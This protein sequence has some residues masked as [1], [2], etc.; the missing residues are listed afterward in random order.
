MSDPTADM[1]KTEKERL[2]VQKKQNEEMEK[3][4]EIVSALNDV[5]KKQKKLLKEIAQLEKK[6]RTE[7]EEKRLKALK[8]ITA[9]NQKEIDQLEKKNKATEELLGTT[10][11]I[12]TT[13]EKQRALGYDTTKT[14]D[15][16]RDL[17]IKY[18]EVE[19]HTAKLGKKKVAKMQEQIEAEITR[20]KINDESARL[21]Q[22]EEKMRKKMVGQAEEL[23]ESA[24]QNVAMAK[25]FIR[26]LAT[27]PYLAILAAIMAVVKALEFLNAKTKEF[28]KATNTSVVQA[29]E[30]RN[31]LAGAQLDAAML[32]YS[33]S[34]AAGALSK[35][36]GS[37]S[38]I[39]G[40]TVKTMGR[41]EKGLNISMSTSAKLMKS[42]EGVGASSDEAQVNS[43]KFAAE[44]AI[45]NDV[46]PGDV[47]ESIAGDTESF[48]KYG[49][50]GGKNM[51]RAAV[52]AK[53]LGLEMSTLAKMSDSLLNFESSI[54]A[55]MEA[56]MLIGKQLNYNKA[57]ELALSGDLE[58]ATK[59]IMSQIGGAAEFQKMNVMQR[60]ALADSV[61]VSVEELSKMA[62]GKMELKAPDKTSEEKLTESMDT[63]KLAMMNL[64]TAENALKFAII[65]LTVAMI[66]NTAAQLF[67]GKGSG[68]MDKLNPFSRKGGKG[69]LTK[70]GK[71]DMRFRANRAPKVPK[72]A[73]LISRG[74]NF[75]KGL[76]GKGKGVLAGGI[77]LASGVAS[78]GLGMAKSGFGMAK[79][80]AGKGFGL[81]KK[82]AGKGLGFLKS[83]KGLL[84]K[85]GKNIMKKV[86]GKALAK[87]LSKGVGKSLLKK[88]PGVGL[89]AGLGFAAQRLMKG[90][91]LGALGELASGAA[92]LLPGIGTAVSVAIDGAM[93]ARDVSK[94]SKDSVDMANKTS[95]ELKKTE[96][97]VL[98]D[99][100]KVVEK[101]KAAQV[102]AEKAVEKA[103]SDKKKIMMTH[104]GLPTG[105]EKMNKQELLAEF[106]ET[107]TRQK[108]L[109]ATQAKGF[110]NDKSGWLSSFEK[111]LKDNNERSLKQNEILLTSIVEAIENLEKTTENLKQDA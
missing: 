79:G 94:T 13:G 30:L 86:G 69:P 6:K 21:M 84:G 28:Q 104:S 107:Y 67:S 87:G 11:D 64:I 56:S 76:L 14:A 58:G 93:I 78:K 4:I 59:N 38:K 74:M 50:D 49:Q 73:G 88:I 45:A 111:S 2:E 95:E 108:K 53:K 9:E 77:G 22:G 109:K 98:A 97:K 29:K 1:M 105:Q 81:A 61:G 83:G 34:E 80:V 35:E 55:E 92:S 99:K 82:F 48:A 8:G 47:M 60:Q 103:G 12:L 31:E 72:K 66:A 43:M 7:K 20:I 5:E 57:R 37:L 18:L 68:I 71:P 46:A 85:V 36:F 70:S 25:S 63:S 106:D 90:D 33:A 101:E 23:V 51:I 27:N 96:K 10:G 89:V 110:D 3:R 44:L 52:A 40:E 19:K 32:G 24:K 91:G 75:G 26:V 102:A 41:F 62:S 54:S 42:M 100:A 65:A 39:N 16:L 17:A 15:K